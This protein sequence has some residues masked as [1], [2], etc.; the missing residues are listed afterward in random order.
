MPILW[1]R[2]KDQTLGQYLLRTNASLTIGRRQGNDVIIDNLAVSGSH[3]KI[4]WLDEGV[5]LTDLGSKNGTFLN[6]KLTTSAW[7][8][9]DDVITI[10]KHTL[11]LTWAE[12]ERQPLVPVPDQQKMDKTMVLDTGQYRSMLEKST[13]EQPA[14]AGRPEPAAVIS[15]LRGGQGEVLL[16]KKLS[17]IGKDRS[18]D[19]VI[20]GLLVGK[21]A[22]TI[23]K[24]PNGF[25]LSYVAGFAKPRV[26]GR[27]ITDAVRLQ[28][29]DLIDIGPARMEFV[30]K[31]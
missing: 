30:T 12:G 2:Y 6:G 3:A 25:F 27:R 21:T 26:N 24:R 8:K 11:V 20:S 17:K 7:I 15:F 4:D 31:E 19:I 16:K 28:D 14:E 1:L 18:N 9:R 5:L 29:F 10:G 22:A 23:S 13:P